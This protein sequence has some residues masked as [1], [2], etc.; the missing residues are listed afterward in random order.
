MVLIGSEVRDRADRGGRDAGLKLSATVPTVQCAEPGDRRGGHLDAVAPRRPTWAWRWGLTATTLAVVGALAPEPVRSTAAAVLCLGTLLAIVI[1]VRLNRPQPAWPWWMWVPTGV[2]FTVGGVLREALGTTG[3]LSAGRSLWPD[4]FTIPAYLL[5]AVALTGLLRA[6]EPGRDVAVV[7][8]CAIL[9][10]GAL[11]L[12]WTV[13][14]DTLLVDLDAATQAK[15]GILSYPP[16]SVVLVALAARLAFSPGRQIVSYRI[17]LA[18]MVGLLFGDLLY[19]FVEAGAVSLPGDLANLPYAL[20]YVVAGAATLHPSMTRVVS[21]D[22]RTRGQL[23]AGAWCWCRSPSWRPPRCSWGGRRTTA[24][25]AWPSGWR[26]GSSPPWRSCAWPRRC[27]SS[28]GPRRR[29]RTGPP[30]MP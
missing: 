6:R 8:D 13:L 14:S 19:L 18:G 12:G 21:F 15:L 4:V 3:D 16:I 29:W 23:T 25:S 5:L 17:L 24:P 26:P 28:R 27:A 20:A 7:L 9:A 2:L 30:T 22:S 11:L 1:G 10:V